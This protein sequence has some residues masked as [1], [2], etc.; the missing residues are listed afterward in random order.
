MTQAFR[1]FR[2]SDLSYA[3]SESRNQAIATAKEELHDQLRR[4]DCRELSADEVDLYLV[5]DADET[6]FRGAIGECYLPHVIT[7]YDNCAHGSDGDGYYECGCPGYNIA[8]AWKNYMEA[9]ANNLPHGETPR[10]PLLV[11]NGEAVVSVSIGAKID[12]DTVVR[13][14]VEL[15]LQLKVGQE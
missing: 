6:V 10:S 7:F 11:A 9:K 4:A 13:P 5:K 1:R 2:V 12:W 14:V 8:P 15:I 3:V